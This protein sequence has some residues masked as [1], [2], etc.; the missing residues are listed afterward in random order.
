M[1]KINAPDL[2]K[3]PPR[4]PRV[5]LGGYV[6]LPRMLDK[7]RATLMKTNGDFHFNCPL[8]AHFLKFVGLKAVPILRQLS[9]GLGDGDVLNWIR[10][11]AKYKR[12]EWEI[13]VWSNDQEHRVPVKLEER[14]FFNGLHQNIA[15][16]R[17]DIASWFDMLDVDDYISYG[18]KV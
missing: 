2:T 3:R 1:K 14:T 15:P 16:K 13:S 7:G 5:R 11:H 6:I 4:S 8:D 12:S 18:G 17:D 10:R 9:L